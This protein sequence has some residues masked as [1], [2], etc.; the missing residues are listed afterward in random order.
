MEISFKARKLK[1][2]FDKEKLL[3]K[4]YGKQKAGKIKLRMA[5]LSS[6]PSL[7]YVPHFPPE[8]RHQLSGK[9]KNEFAVDV[10]QNYRL[11]FTPN[12]N[13]IPTIKDGGFDLTKIIAITILRVE[14]YH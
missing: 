13:P 7:V 12:H 2:V 11:V 4:E 6:A 3:I 1:K 14:D 8:R 9:K 10:S 5:V